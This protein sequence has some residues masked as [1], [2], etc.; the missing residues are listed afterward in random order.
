M[1][2]YLECA[3]EKKV[4]T[5]LPHLLLA[6][7]CSQREFA[8][9]VAPLRGSLRCTGLVRRRSRGAPS[10]VQAGHTRYAAFLSLLLATP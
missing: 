10:V 7:T 5:P 3:R 8:W 9:E 1:W 6:L 4:V 2:W